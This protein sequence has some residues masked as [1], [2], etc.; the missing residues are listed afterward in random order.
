M[1][2][3]PEQKIALFRNLFRGR[4]DVFAVRWQKADG[5]AGGYAPVCRNE[6]KKEICLKQQGR[7][8]RECQNAQYGVLQDRNVEEHLRGLKTIGIYPMLSDNSTYFLAVDFD[9]E[10]WMSQASSFW[11]KCNEKGLQSYIERSRS[12]NG[13]HVWL[14]FESPYPAVKSRALAFNIL[15]ECHIIDAFAK[16]DSFDRIFPN[17]DFLSGKGLGNLIALP[18][19]GE[20]RKLGNSVFIDP[21]NDFSPFPDQ[22]DLLQRIERVPVLL[23]DRMQTEASAE[24]GTESVVGSNEFLIVLRE[25][26][27]ITQSTL[28]R[29]AINFLKEN[30]NF[31]NSEYLIKSRIGLRTP[32][33]PKYFNL[34]QKRN[35]NILIPRGFLPHFVQF[36]K[37]KRIQFRLSDQRTKTAPVFFRSG[38]RLFPRQMDAVEKLIAAEGGVLV[39]PPGSGKTIIGIELIARLQ[40]RALI[41]VHK[42]QIFTQWL[43]RL[44]N[45]LGIPRQE[46]GVVG[47]GKKNFSPQI[48]L[49]M[50]QTLSR[51]KDFGDVA[52]S[53]GLVI[54]DECHHVPAR[55]FRKVIQYLC[56]FYLYGLTA[57]PERKYNDARMIFAYIGDIVHTIPASGEKETEEGEAQVYAASVCIRKTDLKIPFAVTTKNFQML[58]KIFTHDTHRNELIAGDIREMVGRGFRCLVLSERKEHLN[59]LQ[60]YLKRECETM[61]FSGDVP[62]KRRKAR[63]KRILKGDFQVLLATGQMLGEGSDFPNLDCLFMVFPFSFSGKLAQYV[64]RVGRNGDGKAR[65]FD[66]RD[67]EIE[68]LEKMFR[69]RYS[70][71]RKKNLLESENGFLS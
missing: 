48:T 61:V 6:W 31:A 54:V 36:L 22:W 30:L 38:Y 7:K 51:M 21:E 41:L 8:C 55:T 39:A 67:I 56:P 46:I 62:Q 60:Q 25:Y 12:G 59:V 64:G 71:Y 28:P 37:E 5:S 4:N 50:I 57:T 9:G 44:E 2:L 66:Y 58:T 23:L 47:N 34:I 24:I 32:G 43:D 27:E 1:K 29:Q 53:F 69:K 42:K 49:A 20:S 68:Y 18:L 65:V 19:Q 45:G 11:K 40:Q 3:T 63:I 16:E 13:A 33:I 17:Q 14:F 10:S 26:A 70:F 15:K 35:E 52:P